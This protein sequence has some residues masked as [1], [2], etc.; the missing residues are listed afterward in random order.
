MTF[1]KNQNS[2]FRRLRCRLFKDCCGLFSFS[3]S[4]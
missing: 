4:Q 2:T 3:F 1:P